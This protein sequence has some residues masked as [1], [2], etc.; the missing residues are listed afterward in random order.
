MTKDNGEP[1]LN[2]FDLTKETKRRIEDATGNE[3]FECD[4]HPL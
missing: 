1:I 2:K 3:L 4:T